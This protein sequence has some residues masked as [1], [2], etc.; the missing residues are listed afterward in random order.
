[1]SCQQVPFPEPVKSG[2]SSRPH[3]SGKS[4]KSKKDRK[5]K[6]H[7][8]KTSRRN[9]DNPLVTIQ[10]ACRQST[11]RLRK[12]IKSSKPGK[13]RNCKKSRKQKKEK[14]RQKSS[15]D[16]EKAPPKTS[17]SAS[18]QP[19]LSPQVKI[20]KKGRVEASQEQD[21]GVTGSE[22]R[23]S[24]TAPPTAKE[25]RYK[26]PKPQSRCVSTISD[27]AVA[28]KKKRDK[29]E[30]ESDKIKPKLLSPG[31]RPGAHKQMPNTIDS[32]DESDF[33]ES[34]ETTASAAI[35]YDTS[36]LTPA[37]GQS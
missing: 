9:E 24:K 37:H 18:C 25:K 15:Q 22:S 21:M 5:D 4:K 10:L 26:T 32:D 28:T 19:P 13:S 33:M 35:R 2:K 17:Q 27:P 34:M 3:D 7:R 14:R 30:K 12:L 8:Q 16:H 36:H 6:K 11:P 29:K 23:R 1:M 31:T 20:V